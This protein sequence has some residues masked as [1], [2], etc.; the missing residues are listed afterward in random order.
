MIKF[1]CDLL[2]YFYMA[3]G[4]KLTWWWWLTT[5]TTMHS[6]KLLSTSYQP[7]PHRFFC[8]INQVR[9]N[10]VHPQNTILLNRDSRATRNY[11]TFTQQSFFFMISAFSASSILTLY[12]LLCTHNKI[13]LLLPSSSNWSSSFLKQDIPPHILTAVSHIGWYFC[14]FSFVVFLLTT[15]WL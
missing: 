7:P 11:F 6:T 12:P 15:M 5:T 10:N 13:F 8:L 1:L 3:K 2:W 9:L 14:K 4:E